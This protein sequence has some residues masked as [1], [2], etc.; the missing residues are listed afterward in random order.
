MTV[1]ESVSMGPREHPLVP[2]DI[3]IRGFI[4]DVRSVEVP[5]ATRYGMA[6]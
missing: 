6:A 1:R 2:R 5:E 4:I 3:P